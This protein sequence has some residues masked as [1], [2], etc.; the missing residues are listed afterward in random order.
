M[1]NTFSG[2]VDPKIRQRYPL[3]GRHAGRYYQFHQFHFQIVFRLYS[4]SLEMKTGNENRYTVSLLLYVIF[5]NLL[6]TKP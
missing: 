6:F 1:E 3:R 5:C 2:V 4:S